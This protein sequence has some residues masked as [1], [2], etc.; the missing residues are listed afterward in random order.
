M[1][2]N[3]QFPLGVEASIQENWTLPLMIQCASLLDA[4]NP[5]QQSVS[6][7]WQVYLHLTCAEWSLPPSSLTK[8]LLLNTILCTPAFPLPQEIFYPGNGQPFTR[9]AALLHGIP[10]FNIMESWMNIWSSARS[11]LVEFGLSPANKLPPGSDLLRKEWSTLNRLRT[12]VGRF[13][14]CLSKWGLRSSSSCSC[15]PID[16]T[17]DHVIVCPLNPA[18]SGKRGLM[19]VNEPTRR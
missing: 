2:Q 11:R 16:Q 4:S 3:T 17:A 15:G 6:Q 18:P 10:Q 19:L 14:Y 12:G 8:L 5:L 9:H 1:Q 7:R 13:N